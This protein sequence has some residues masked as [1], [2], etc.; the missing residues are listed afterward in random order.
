MRGGMGLEIMVECDGYYYSKYMYENMNWC[1]YTMYT[2]RD[3]KN[4]SICIIR[5]VM[6][7]AVTH[8]F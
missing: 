6:H 8:K 4:C 3:M 2:T 7:S 1:E 5:I